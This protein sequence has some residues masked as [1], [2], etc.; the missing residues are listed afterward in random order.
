MTEP[1]R[2]KQ[3]MNVLFVITDQQRADHS[4]FRGNRV[5][6]TPNMD[7]IAAAGMVFDQ[8]WVS[9]PVCMPNRATI[10][11]GRMPSAHGV[12][13]NDRSLDWSSNTFVRRFRKS[14]YRTGLIGKSHLQH[15]TSKNSMVPFR[16]ESSGDAPYPDGWDEVEDFE[17]YLEHLPE[18]PTG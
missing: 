15:G 1:E 8:A 2:S 12:V 6:E 18:N 9:N 7:S 16:G 13:F 11:T 14:G 17:H 4:G 5:V 10:M 3:P